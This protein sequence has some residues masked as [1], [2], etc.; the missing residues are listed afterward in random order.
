MHQ[1]I[2][3]VVGRAH[4]VARPEEMDTFANTQS[5]GLSAKACD[6]L[7]FSHYGQRHIGRQ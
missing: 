5:L 6:L 3:R 2:G 1:H 7:A 4:I